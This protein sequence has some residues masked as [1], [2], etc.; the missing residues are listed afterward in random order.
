MSRSG[1][2]PAVIPDDRKALL[3]AVRDT[4][5]AH[6]PPELEEG[7]QYGMIGWYVPHAIYPAGYHVD[8]APYA[9]LANQKNKVSL[10]LFCAYL[11]SELVRDFQERY[12]N[13]LGKKPDMGKSC[14][15]FAKAADV[16]HDLIGEVLK[17]MTL[18]VFLDR[19][20]AQLP[21]R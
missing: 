21:K 16:P 4:V 11:D 9:G 6:R 5:N 20:T 17:R 10:H 2:G 14:V 15:R 7:P 13:W 1:D 18:A 3:A 12:R 8:P 19:Y